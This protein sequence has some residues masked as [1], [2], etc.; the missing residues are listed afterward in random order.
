MD[1]PPP[2]KGAK[3]VANL[4]RLL[5]LVVLLVGILGGAQLWQISFARQTF[6]VEVQV[7]ADVTGEGNQSGV[8]TEE[9]LSLGQLRLTIPAREEPLLTLDL[10]E[11]TRGEF[12]T[13]GR[14][15]RN[16]VEQGRSRAI[17]RLPDA[18]PDRPQLEFP[19]ASM[20]DNRI[21][22]E[23]THD[24][25]DEFLGRSVRA[26]L[27]VRN[28]HGTPV[29]GLTDRLGEL[30]EQGDGVYHVRSK[31]DDVLWNVL[32]GVET[33]SLQ[34]TDGETSFRIEYPFRWFLAVGDEAHVVE[35]EEEITFERPRLVA[36]RVSPARVSSDGG[37]SGSLQ[38]GG[39]NLDLADDVT[40]V[41]GDRRIR[42]R[43]EDRARGS[44]RLVVDPSQLST[45]RWN[46]ELDAG[47]GDAT[48]LAGALT[49]E[50]GFA[51]LEPADGLTVPHD[52]DIPLRWRAPG[53]VGE[54]MLEASVGDGGAWQLLYRG[55]ASIGRTTASAE[56]LDPG[57]HRIR[58]TAPGGGDLPV[59]TRRIIVAEAPYYD[60]TFRFSRGG[61]PYANVLEL[62]VDG[63]RMEIGADPGLIPVQLSPGTYSVRARGGLNLELQRTIEV[64][65]DGQFIDLEFAP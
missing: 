23:L 11:T 46:L 63:E 12:Q 56:G 50:P 29:T 27:A 17:L 38:V 44:L 35:V 8:R 40:L 9:L 20:E 52:G 31:L 14:A 53:G 49:V 4:K 13:V 21:L 34:A 6:S 37:W 30:E 28:Q 54:V 36:S 10:S 59:R 41:R 33:A 45:G 18:D 16:E 2:R 39:E 57:E 26:L 42:C 64:S 7:E 60:V 61:V 5:L 48:V 24:A 32:D 65:E 43:V 1:A 47:T 19:L 51:L 22:L 3:L 55:D 15:E 58:L 25:A 62:I